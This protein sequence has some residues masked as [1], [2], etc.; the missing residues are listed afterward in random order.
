MYTDVSCDISYVHLIR[1]IFDNQNIDEN[2]AE[3]WRTQLT[4]RYVQTIDKESYYI[5]S[6]VGYINVCL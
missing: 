2:N 4:K 1:A 6:K 5:F 3:T